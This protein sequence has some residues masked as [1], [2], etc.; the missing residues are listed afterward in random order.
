MEYSL[1][2]VYCLSYFARYIHIMVDTPSTTKV[3]VF[4]QPPPSTQKKE[5]EKPPPKKRQITESKRWTAVPETLDNQLEILQQCFTSSTESSDAVRLMERQ[6]HSKW[7]GYRNQDTEKTIYDPAAFLTE[8]DI[9]DLLVDSRLTCFYCRKN[10]QLFY[11]YVRESLQWTIERI[12]NAHG[13][14]RG[15]TVIACLGCNL[16]RKTMYYERFVMTKQMTISKLQ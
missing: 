3:C 7:Y 10:V 12:D 1:Y 4:I 8:R 15:N 9:V 14:N 6:I 5:K 2:T 13:H 11:E 16:R